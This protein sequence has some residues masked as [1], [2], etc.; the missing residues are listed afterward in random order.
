[1]LELF[2]WLPSPIEGLRWL[3]VNVTWA[4][5]FGEDAGAYDFFQKLF[6][7]ISNY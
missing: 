1:M 6:I 5:I 7:I 2:D 4:F 3:L